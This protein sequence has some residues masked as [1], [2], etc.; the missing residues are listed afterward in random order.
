[1]PSEKRI[2]ELLEFAGLE[3]QDLISASEC[4]E[5]ARDT[6]KGLTWD[7][8]KVRLFRA[9]EIADMLS[10]EDERLA[11]VMPSLANWDIAPMVNITAHGDNVPWVDGRPVPG[12]WLNKDPNSDEY[13]QAVAAN[14]WCEGEHPRSKKSRK[15][16]YRR[17]AGEFRAWSLGIPL[18]LE[19]DE[20]RQWLGMGDDKSVNV[21][22]VGDAW[23]LRA[24]TKLIPGVYLKTRIG[25]EVDNIIT[26]AGVQGW[27][28]A[29]RFDL[30][31]PLT[32]SVLPTL[33][34]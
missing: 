34:P 9:G 28:P 12:V 20:R 31:A 29:P 5:F 3:G 14:Y 18:D 33:K 17:N 30:R 21:Y 16:W 6:A 11:D 15:A 4:L 23:L 19:H 8:W 24:T 32:W 26:P 27:Y 7:K 10:W 1:M 22:R 2:L 13:K 25:Y